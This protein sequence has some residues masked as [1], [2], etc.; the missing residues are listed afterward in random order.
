MPEVELK[1]GWTRVAFGDV[2]KLSRERTNDP[3]GDGFNRYVGL[4][5]IEPGDLKIRR[6]GNIADGTT[7]TSVFRPGQVLFGKRRAYQRKV[8]LADFSGVC[9]GDIYVLEPKNSTLLPDLLPF[10]CQT[11]GFFEH[12]VGTSAGSLSP[13][14]N[15]DSLSRYEFELPSLEEQHRIKLALAAYDLNLEALRKLKDAALEVAKSYLVR[16]FPPATPGVKSV[17]FGDMLRNGNLLFQTGPFGTVLSAAEYKR[18]GWPIINPTHIR[19][20]QIIHRDGPCVD[21][22]TATKLSRYRMQAGDILLAR[23]GEIEKA[24]LVSADQN[25][26]IVGSDCILLRPNQKMMLGGYLLMFLRA[27]STGRMLRSFAQGTVMLGLNE[28]VLGRLVVPLKGLEAQEREVEFL[29]AI[30]S[31]TICLNERLDAAS[32][33]RFEFLSNAFKRQESR[34]TECPTNTVELSDAPIGRKTALDKLSASLTKE[35]GDH[36]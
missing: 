8:A 17:A 11:D 29:R 7:F 33:I 27:P 20:G 23:K 26:W 21:D 35:T 32:V 22:A 3:E 4:E 16:L 15:W 36:G 30:D 12:A 10:L 9:S 6:W 25:G 19:E 13:R 5:H 24:C 2:V 31:G 14:T 34:S 18:T 1:K 28:E